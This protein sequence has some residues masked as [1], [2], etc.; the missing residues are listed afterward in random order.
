MYQ[1]AVR[2]PV[3]GWAEKRL[4]TLSKNDYIRAESASQSGFGKKIVNWIGRDKVYPNNVL[5]LATECSYRGHS[6]AFPLELPIW[7]IK[8]FTQERDIVLDPFVGVGTTALAA[9]K[10]GRQYVG[11]EIRE[12]YCERAVHVL[13]TGQ[14]SIAI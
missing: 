7:F 14:M 13:D 5:H 2:V 1:D 9:K 10:L 6:A 12:A 3:G 8:L 11:I 4:S